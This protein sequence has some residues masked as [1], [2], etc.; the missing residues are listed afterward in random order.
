MLLRRF[1]TVELVYVLVAQLFLVD[2]GYLNSTVSRIKDLFL[3]GT[4]WK[5]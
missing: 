1:E 3:F 5:I 2:L 4:A